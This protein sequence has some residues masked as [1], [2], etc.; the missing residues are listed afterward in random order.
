MVAALMETTKMRKAVMQKTWGEVGLGSSKR[1]GWAWEVYLSKDGELYDRRTF[2][3][4][5][6]AGWY[7]AVNCCTDWAD[8][9][10]CEVKWSD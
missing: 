8:V 6:G 4:Y 7:A 9:A 3:Y 5:K 10:N 1:N 2:D